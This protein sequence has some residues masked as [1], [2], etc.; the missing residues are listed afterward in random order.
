MSEKDKG[1]T[2]PPTTEY[3]G[4]TTDTKPGF[5]ISLVDNI[6]D[7][8]LRAAMQELVKQNAAMAT[9]NK[10]L[11]EIVT[12]QATERELQKFEK[13]RSEKLKTLEA[14]HPALA[15]THKDTKDLG[16]LD[17]AISTAQAFKSEFS[18]YDA[19]QTKDK[20]DK[21]PKTYVVPKQYGPSR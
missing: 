6:Q 18:E 1:G 19:K 11:T 9:S 20:D 16:I 4:K 17:T 15:E 7:A 14:L 3:T 21:T 2:T 13:A 8:E 12:K 10:E 5:K